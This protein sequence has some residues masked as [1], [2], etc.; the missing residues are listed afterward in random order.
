MSP[1]QT[2]DYDA[3]ARQHGG[4]P[5]NN[6][7]ENVPDSLQT[8]VQRMVAAGESDADIRLV[9]QHY[10]TTVNAQA[11][12]PAEAI[13]R[14]VK[15][16]DRVKASV[17]QSYHDATDADDLAQRL[18]RM[19]LPQSTKAALW[20]AKE[21]AADPFAA[22][23]VQPASTARTLSEQESSAI[24]DRLMQQAPR[25]L[26]EQDFNRWMGPRLEAALGEAENSPAKPEG[27]AVGR[28]FSNAGEMLN[29]L[30]L[31]R[32][33]KDMVAHPINTATN[34][35]SAQV[36]QG[37]QAVDMARQGRYWES[38][39]HALASVLP[40]VGPAAAEAGEQIASGDIAGGLG[41]GVGLLVPTAG[42]TALRAGRRVLAGAL[43]GGVR[44]AAAGALERTAAGKLADVMAPKVGANKTRFGG[45]AEDVAPALAKDRGLGAYSREGLHARVAERLDAATSALDA[46]S[47]ARLSA[48]TFG[49]KPVVDALLE[50]RRQLTAET[51][52]A[53]GVSAGR[54]EGLADTSKAGVS[55]QEY[56]RV[57]PTRTTARTGEAYGADVVPAPNRARVAEIDQA[58]KEI[59]ALGPAA[60]Y[61][62]LRRIRQAY[63]GPAKARYSP[64]M[65]ADYMKVQ[66]EALGAADVTGALRDHLAKLDPRTAEANAQYSLFRKAND[67]L[68]ATAEV[69]RTRPKVGR[70]IIARMTGTVAGGQAAGLAGAATGYILGPVVDAA[71]DAGWT[72]QIKTAQL[73]SKLATAIRR[74]SE[75]E[76]ISLATQLQH[77]GKRLGAQS[78]TLTGRSP[79]PMSNEVTLTIR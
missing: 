65:T 56:G 68:E 71:M 23:A 72:T 17:W 35:L 32:G 66:G 60:R 33:V 7:P 38:G 64:S 52:D 24:R 61:E 73:M 50:K 4:A 40:V 53:S 78:A 48:R 37:R 54:I 19:A 79:N 45:M 9:I 16:P 44:A 14:G 51:V 2:P 36:A 49:T 22:Y 39:G 15:I 27:S 58:I 21:Q 46:A 3:L 59:Q 11:A 34:V 76:V 6:G 8:I 26:S 18:R 13:L 41:K 28:F 31:A 1:S 70:R 42:P 20:D 30:A 12:D 43:P 29:P 67:V 63:D 74:G 10:K 47:D 55:G 69:E 77:L 62:S 75:G 25:G 57:P 5:V